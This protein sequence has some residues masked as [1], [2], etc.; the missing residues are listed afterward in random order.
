MHHKVKVAIML[1]V[2]AISITTNC[3]NVQAIAPTVI[4]TNPANGDTDVTVD[5]NIEVTFSKQINRSK[6]N[7]RTFILK[8]EG[9]NRHLLG[10]MNYS[11][12]NKRVSF[13][14][15][16]ALT[17]NTQYIFRIKGNDDSGSNI[18]DLSGKA[19]KSDYVWS[20]RTGP[21]INTNS[22]SPIVSFTNPVNGA[23]SVE[24]NVK[25]I[26]SFDQTVNSGNVDFSLRQGLSPIA[27]TVSYLAKSAIFTPTN[28]LA[29]NT[30]YT[31]TITTQV[32]DLNG[33]PVANDYLWS[34]TTGT[35]ADTS[36]PTV[37]LVSPLNGS[38]NIAINSNISIDFSEILDPATVTTTTIKL[39][40]GSTL[41]PGSVTYSGTTVT[42]DSTSNLASNSTYRATITTQVKDLAGNSLATNYVWSFT[43]SQALD[44]SSPTVQSVS[45]VNGSTSVALNRSLSVN[46]SEALDPAT[47][48][49]TTFILE[50][51]TTLIPGTVTYSGTTASFSSTNNLVSNSTY[52][53]T[54]TTGVKDLAG[55]SLANNYVWRFTTGTNVNQSETVALQSSADFAILA[56]STVTNTGATIINGNLGLSPGSAVTGFP[57]GNVIGIQHIN[58][59]TSDQAKLD[60]TAA[61]NDAAGRTLAPITVSGNIGG[62]TL[63]PGLYKSTSTLAI[64]AGDLTLDAQGDANAVFIFQIASGF[65]VTSGRQ[66]ILSGGALASN[67][68][69][70]VG[71]SATIGTT[72]VFKGNILTD[73][74]ITFETGASLDGRALT[75][76]GAVSLDSNTI[77][78]P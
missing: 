45:P 70:Q 12:Q 78:K 20:F 5:Q 75:R 16:K 67:I 2:F 37:V 40:Q 28:N 8:E 52:R 14:P 34:F 6:I 39:E 44:I 63:A 41:I 71:T 7:K 55:N 60:L 24:T 54:V 56:G 57:P 31:A 77:T 49:T 72:A 47:V 4:L 73:Q 13:Q 51:G 30:T 65:T 35:S 27:G 46:F 59:P 61:Y 1:L 74:S 22:S 17:N 9:S 50:Q 38:T 21:N 48:T 69:W 3:L 43:T 23:A 19:M 42:F 32:D 58:D 10:R 11:K 26:A 29:I 66:V 76:I 62:Q 64:S 53:A 36:S 68:F 33:N 15:R 25:V 18:R